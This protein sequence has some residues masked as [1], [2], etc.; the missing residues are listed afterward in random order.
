MGIRQDHTEVHNI[1]VGWKF[2]NV[3]LDFCCIYVKLILAT[4]PEVQ[5]LLRMNFRK[6]KAVT[7]YQKGELT[8][9]TT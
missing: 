9:I 1:V 2:R 5:K 7:F 3:K 4:L 6:W 8:Q